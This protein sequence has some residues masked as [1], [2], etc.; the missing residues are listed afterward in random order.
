RAW[1]QQAT[2]EPARG[3]SRE[4]TTKDCSARDARGIGNLRTSMSDTKATTSLPLFAT[5]YR[6]SGILLHVTSLPS[7]Y[8][9]GDVGPSALGW[10]DR[11]A[12]AGQS[13]WQALPLGPTGYG[14]SPYQ[15]L[16]SFAGNG[17]LISPD[18][19]IEDRLLNETD[20]DRLAFPEH[21]VDYG[22]V[23]PFKHR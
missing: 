3:T 22:A 18:F 12:E 6:A 13:W 4:Q 2:R 1:D 10:I 7:P 17:I 9:I 11:I 5:D 23:I 14:T 20:F 19:L 21:F 16:S 8:G 15:S